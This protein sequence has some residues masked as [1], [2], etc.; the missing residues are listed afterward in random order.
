[1]T[2]AATA[3]QLIGANPATATPPGIPTA[4]TARSEL[5]TL[6]V[7]AW[8]H[9]TTYQRSLFST[10]DTITGTCD[11]RETRPAPARQGRPTR[12]TGP[13][14]ADGTSSSGATRT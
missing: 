11:T 3:I 9:T 7:P 10:W 14:A 12:R 1:M 13:A 6:T 8:T 4:A 2:T 5:S